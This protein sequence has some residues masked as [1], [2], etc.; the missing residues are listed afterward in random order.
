MADTAV[1]VVQRD[2]PEDTIVKRPDTSDTLRVLER[3]GLE[4]FREME[5]LERT[6]YSAEYITPAEEAY[7]WYLCA[8]STT[9]ALA[10]DGAGT[11]DSAH[12]VGFINLFPVS[13]Q[14]YQG[15]R[16]GTFNDRDLT[17]ADVVA[18]PEPGPGQA[19]APGTSGPHEAGL[20]GT[21]PHG[22]KS[23]EV[24]SH[25]T[26]QGEA[27]PLHMFLSCILVDEAHRGG[28]ATRHLLQ[29]AVARYAT[30]EHLVNEIVTDNV[31]PEGVRFSRRWGFAPVCASDHGSQ[32]FAQPYAAFARRVREAG[33]QV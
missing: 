27:G 12:I 2:A 17:A 24:G 14:V 25:V 1:E 26:S 15:I 19:A 31:T 10:D 6:C 29:K 18:L 3:L 33:T 22:H 16:A 11:H 32:V 21:K 13:E 8:P 20:L 7:A 5:A 30:V 9:I 4:H 28:V 23:H